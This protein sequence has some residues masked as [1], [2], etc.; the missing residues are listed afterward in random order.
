MALGRTKLFTKLKG[1]TGQTPNQFITN[2]RL[3]TSITLLET[4]PG[5]SVGEISYMVGFNSPSY[6]IKSFHALYGTTPTAYRN[7]LKNKQKPN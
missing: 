7:N 2:I 4:E 5:L 6:F 3:K 1:V